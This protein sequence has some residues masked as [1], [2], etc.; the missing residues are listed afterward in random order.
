M[1]ARKNFPA[2][3]KSVRAPCGS[4]VSPYFSVDL[5]ALQGRAHRL[6]TA[7]NNFSQVWV[8]AAGP[9]LKVPDLGQIVL[10]ALPEELPGVSLVLRVLVVQFSEGLDLGGLADLDVQ[11]LQLLENKSLDLAVFD[12]V[13]DRP[14]LLGLVPLRAVVD[15]VAAA[16]AGVAAV[17]HAGLHRPAAVPADQKR[18]QVVGAGAGAA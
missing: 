4:D 12:A 8:G 6:M 11:D 16:L 15:R 18:A 10:H 5:P 13:A 14:V 2:G 7:R 1:A 17:L 3:H 9:L